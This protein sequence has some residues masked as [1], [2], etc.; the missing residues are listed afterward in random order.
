MADLFD[1]ELRAR[2]RD[3]AFRSG[4]ELFL[5]ER[6]FAD[7]LDRLGIVRR[8]FRTAVLIGCP[9]PG[10]VERLREFADTI[11]VFDPGKAFAKAAQGETIVEDRFDAGIGR[12]ELG[13]AIGTLDTVNDLPQA[14]LRIRATL[15]SDAL[16]LGALSAGDTLPQLRSA[17]R[18]ADQ[19]D[20]VAVPHVHPRI[21][22][23]ALAGLLAAAGFANPV[24]DV[25]RVRA[26]YELLIGL[27][28]DLRRM[29]ATN[30]LT[31]RSRSSLS[32]S[33]WEAAR[34][35]FADAAEDGRT[36]ETFEILHFAAWTPDQ[37]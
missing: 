1:M 35:A 29:G 25:D 11:D 3:R 19:V 5:L 31:R 13:L 24:I 21:E 8:R 32:K 9:D 26:S 12:Y 34:A 20:G 18:A 2:R 27:V 36:T 23:A 17:M 6:A 16:F 33:A 15:S 30:V 7:C 14:L 22:A 28:A 10:W 37:G 4:P